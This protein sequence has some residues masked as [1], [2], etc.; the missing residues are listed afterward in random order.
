MKP[1]QR[2]AL[3][4]LAGVATGVLLAV[5]LV[6]VLT[7]S[8]F[9][10][11]R[12]RR[13]AVRWLDEQVEG[14]IE[15]RKI[16]SSGLLQGLMLHN[17]S[18]RDPRG[19]DFVY[20]DSAELVYNWR[21][22][23]GGEI[24]L[25]RVRLY[26]PRVF[27]EQLPQDTLW[28]Y[29][30]VFPDRTPRTQPSTRKLILFHDAEVFNG[31]V[32]IR[33]PF[34]PTGPVAPEDTA[35]SLMERVPG[36]LAKVM[37]FDSVNAD[38]DRVLWESPVEEGKLFRV[39]RLEAIAY[40]FKD[41]V[42]ITEMKG[43]VSTRD[44]VTSFSMNPVRFGAS[45]ATV[46]GR[47]IRV[48]GKANLFDV[49][50]D[51]E[52]LAF[53]DLQW[54]YPRLPDQGSAQ[55][56]LRIQ[57]QRPKGTLWY[58]SNALITAP[59]TRMRGN[60]GVVTGD[61][62]YFTDVDLRASPLN[63]ELLEEILPGKLPV[64][65]LLV[66][67]VEVK[68]PL[69]SLDLKGDVELTQPNATSSSG[70]KFS[71]VFD[72]RSQL[73]ASNFTADLRNV[74]L[75]VLNE[76]Q[77]DLQ[78][79]GVVDGHVEADGVFA[80]RFTFAAALQHQLAGLSSRFEG[81]GTYENR[82]RSLDL[83]MDALPLSFEQLAQV[84]PATKILR[85]EARGP[86]TLTGPIDDLT[87]EAKLAT[88]GGDLEFDG[89]LQLIDGRRRYS[90]QGRLAG[91]Q[92]DRL[93]HHLPNTYVS[94]NVRF[95]LTGTSAADANGRID[96]ELANARISGVP[97]EAVKLTG[98][99]DRG[100]LLLDSLRARSSFGD[101]TGSGDLG[102]TRSTQGTVRFALHTDSIVPLSAPGKT[103]P[104]TGGH[105]EAS[106]TLRGGLG[107][108]DLDADA[109]V[110]R[111]LYGETKALRSTLHLE[112]RQLTTD[113]G[114]L[115]LNAQIDSAE[116]FGEQFDTTRAELTYQ[117]GAGRFALAA[118][119][120]ERAYTL[121]ADLLRDSTALT[122]RVND[123]RAGNSQEPWVLSQPFAIRLDGIDLRADT[124]ALAKTGGDGSIRG[125]GT[126]A[127]ARSRV[128]SLDTAGQPVNFD[129][130]I[131]GVPFSELMHFLGGAH[132]VTG[133]ANGNLR[134][135]GTA[136]QPIMQADATVT[137][138]RYEDT[139]IGLLTASFA[140]AG[141]VAHTRVEAQH[142]GRRIVLGEGSIPIDLG[143]VPRTHR[144]LDR[145]LQFSFRADSMPAAL[146]AGVVGGFDQVGGSMYGT[147]QLGGTTVKPTIAGLLNLRDAS[148]VYRASGVR[149]RDV[150]GTFR[151]LENNLV[152]VEASARTVDNGRASLSGQL[153]FE[154][155]GN[156]QFK[157][158]LIDANRFEAADRR[159]AAF[160]TTGSVTL[161][162]SYRAPVLS[163]G[164]RV[165]RGALYLDELYRQYQVIDLDRALLFNVV[166]TTIVANRALLPVDYKRSP[167]I[168]NL[169]IRNFTIELPGDSWL[170]S[171]NLTMEVSGRL[172]MTFDP[173]G[174][175]V[176]CAGGS[177]SDLRLSG[178]LTAV[179]G[180]YQMELGPLRR[181]FEIREG[182]VEFP[183][184]PGIDPILSITAMHRAQPLEG[185]PIDILAI[186]TGSLQNPRVR[187]A[188]GEGQVSMSES[189]LASYLFFGVPT[190]ALTSAQERQV[191]AVKGIG[192]NE[193][194]SSTF[195]YLSSGLQ[196]FAQDFGLFDYVSLTAAEFAPSSAQAPGLNINNFF[197]GTQ[198]EV[199]RPLPGAE[200]IYFVMSQRLGV[201]S[202]EPGIRVEW[203]FDRTYTMELF[204][205]DRF[206]R[207]AAPFGIERSASFRKVYGFFLFKE[208]S[209]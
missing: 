204:A 142:E 112:G 169:A 29:Q 54:V 72:A 205:E 123:L 130:A 80:D 124:F 9:G 4:S 139:R 203:R 180:T 195:G 85:G 7:R 97:L 32:T 36:G 38:L 197:A 74:D 107:A 8:E 206:A 89:K 84:Y 13:F 141:Q 119:S 1:A 49:V 177:A 108:F 122:V 138:V 156:P 186:V 25:D 44:T 79:K 2:I 151:V 165:D 159:D 69:S 161:N 145:P 208:W 168:R 27:L 86:I 41:P 150:D 134:V 179:R 106:G 128:D 149:Y 88:G 23:L 22:L 146:L 164:I 67:T 196:S 94:G 37:H 98:R 104:I 173:C 17:F 76:L 163:G 110:Q 96:F 62:L 87:V 58:A 158:L 70:V 113:S 78:L 129:L 47:V 51:G 183:G 126:L 170:R 199:G 10:A 5:T 185:T 19:R 189:D 101:L 105:L 57:T 153:N 155:L 154:Q 39:S 148:G 6:L 43:T 52:T 136:G 137:D 90:G 18:I 181:R 191:N 82:S 26:R 40:V 178:E 3:F 99:V 201:G 71:G 81:S 175:Q 166:D 182:T 120:G 144:K 34:R 28:N 187:L 143:F 202:G 73:S 48:E 157:D 114:R 60:F 55:L 117:R 21:T 77:P 65:G 30:I 31:F 92:V 125:G 63:L 61:T 172:Q 14:T 102:I 192:L 200:N 46:E 75:A 115:S 135:N 167:F 45:A 188:S 121:N 207:A 209:R 152:A 118:G 59:G 24:Q 193:L 20:A 174:P 15:I 64:Q 35:R 132:T 11:E 116:V 53:R 190:G 171:R 131:Q 91:F 140:Y 103:P 133:L 56:R 42:R 176:E 95:D 162:G 50:I 93:L 16:T 147:L 66:G 109:S 111:A 198:L 83:R 100:L 160:T 33:T 194:K 12:I 127:W 68:G 184:T